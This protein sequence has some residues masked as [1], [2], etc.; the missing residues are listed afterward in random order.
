MPPRCRA[1]AR[2]CAFCRR[3][4]AAMPR[5]SPVPLVLPSQSLC[6]LSAGRS[7]RGPEGGPAVRGS[8]SLMR[9]VGPGEPGRAD[10][11]EQGR[12]EDRHERGRDGRR[13]LPGR[14]RARRR[15]RGYD[16]S[17]GARQALRWAAG[18]GR[19]AGW[20]LHVVRAWHLTTA[21]TPPTWEPGFR[22]TAA[23]LGGGRSRRADGAGRRCPTGPAVVGDLPRRSRRS[24]ERLIKSAEH[25]DMLVVGSG[26]HGGLASAIAARTV[27]RSRT[28]VSTRTPRVSGATA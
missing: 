8:R 19:W 24:A 21:P 13:C 18:S 1:N 7:G 17:A 16:G 22:S 15:A 28:V 9:P 11:A 26:G 3:H 5:T 2:S 23:R 6:P 12:R 20:D 25:A 10:R 4:R 27:A 14:R